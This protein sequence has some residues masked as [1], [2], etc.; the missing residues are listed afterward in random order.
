MGWVVKATPRP[1]YPRE[2]DAVA[3]VVHSWGPGGALK[4]WSWRLSAVQAELCS[5]MLDGGY[6][7]WGTVL[8][9]ATVTDVSQGPAAS[10]FL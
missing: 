2:G 5:V 8:W 9:N 6:K 3:I 10:M 7:V 1:L 4:V